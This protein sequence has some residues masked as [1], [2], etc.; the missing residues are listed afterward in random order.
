MPSIR[1]GTTLRVE[2]A[3]TMPHMRTSLP[4]AAVL[5]GRDLLHRPLPAGNADL[6]DPGDSKLAR[7]GVVG[8][9]TAGADRRSL[10]DRNRRDEHAVRSDRDVI[11]D[12]RP[13]LGDAVVVRGDR[14][15]AE[16]HTGRWSCRQRRP[17]DW[18]W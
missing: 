6:P 7:G 5:L 2:D 16:V 12:H 11:L 15:G 1:I 4:V 17:G 18:P 8:D 13:V 10:A 9:G 3:P 14:S